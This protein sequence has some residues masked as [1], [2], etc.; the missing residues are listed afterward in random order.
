M[1]SSEFNFRDRNGQGISPCS[2]MAAQPT[3]GLG[4]AGSV[5]DQR[6][7]PTMASES[8]L[9][10]GNR[11]ANIGDRRLGDEHNDLACAKRIP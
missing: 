11:S 7:T 6:N 5:A 10:A 4:N 3:D 2:A 9:T 8:E 1:A